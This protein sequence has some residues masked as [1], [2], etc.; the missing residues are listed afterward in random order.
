M[1]VCIRMLV[2]AEETKTEMSVV[3]ID[4]LRDNPKLAELKLGDRFNVYSSD[5]LLPVETEDGQKFHVLTMSNPKYWA[6]QFES[7]PKVL[8]LLDVIQEF[9]IEGYE[10]FAILKDKR[11][12]YYAY[13]IEFIPLHGQ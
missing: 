7:D 13:W 9:S 3:N 4:I 1:F 5:R 8:E 12:F 11:D 6:V 10:V 2:I